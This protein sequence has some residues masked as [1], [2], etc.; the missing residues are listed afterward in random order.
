MA[1]QVPLSIGF[2]RQEYWSRLPD[3]LL[4]DLPDPGIELTSHY[5]SCIAGG[6]FTTS[7]TWEAGINHTSVKRI[8]SGHSAHTWQAQ[9]GSPRPHSC[10][11][12]P[13][14]AGKWK[15]TCKTKGEKQWLITAKRRAGTEGCG[16]HRLTRSSSTTSQQ[17]M[18]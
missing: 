18:E 8:I 11:P 1:H 13:W 5:V 16:H 3:P 10:L 12:C 4:G 15:Q 6:F 17:Q 9:H 7:A 2:S 14:W